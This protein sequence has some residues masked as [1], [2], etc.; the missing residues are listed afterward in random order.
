MSRWLWSYLSLGI[1]LAACSGDGKK[2][3]DPKPQP[4]K[5]V[6]FCTDQ[7]KNVACEPCDN[8][9]NVS[10]CFKHDEA[11]KACAA[12]SGEGDPTKFFCTT[13]PAP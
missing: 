1:A 4:P 3:E 12:E 6:C 13:Q 10:V 9:T 2:S 8:E 11:C 5:Q 7:K